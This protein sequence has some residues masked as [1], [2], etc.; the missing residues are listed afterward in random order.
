MR[1]VANESFVIVSDIYDD[2]LYGIVRISKL[3][4]LEVDGITFQ[5]IQGGPLRRMRKNVH[6]HRLAGEALSCELTGCPL[7]VAA[8]CVREP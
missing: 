1:L 8:L 2:D 5:F 3:E 4:E 7:Q 6:G